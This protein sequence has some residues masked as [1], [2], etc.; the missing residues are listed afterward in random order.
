MN[1]D[2]Y[3]KS[4]LLIYMG[5]CS[6]QSWYQSCCEPPLS[7]LHMKN[8]YEREICVSTGCDLG[9]DWDQEFLYL[10]RVSRLP[11]AHFRGPFR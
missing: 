1:S 8:L 11:D 6:E 3:E 7:P 9:L 4:L 5:C 10:Q 2:F